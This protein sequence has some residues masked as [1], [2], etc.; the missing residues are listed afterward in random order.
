MTARIAPTCAVTLT[1]DLAPGRGGCEMERIV[2]VDD[3]RNILTS[4]SVLLE[5]EGYDVRGYADSEGAL[6]DLV[7]NPPDL[8]IFDV[9]MPRMDGMELLQK[10]RRH[11]RF[12]VLMLTS[13]DSEVDE[14]QGLRLGADDYITKPFSTRVLL[15]R[16]RACRRRIADTAETETGPRLIEQGPLTVDEGRREV[17]WNGAQV[18]L[19]P[20]EFTLVACLAERPG[21]VRSR[22]QLLELLYDDSVYVEDRSIDSFVKRARR[23]FRT[24]DPGFDAIETLYG[25]GYRFNVP[26]R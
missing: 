2:L 8:A 6:Q 25:L 23:K 5:N 1:G 26:P 15:E 3:D 12:P 13:L 10:V 9:K 4:V 24:V 21:I 16:I 18:P 7:R 14:I 22:E 17:L 20:K 19:T 11:A